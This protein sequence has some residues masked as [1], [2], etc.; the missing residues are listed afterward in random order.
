MKKWK[1][2][3]HFQG[4]GWRRLDNTGKLFAMVAGEDL[5]NVFRVSAVLTEEIDEGRLQEA[6]SQTLPEFQVFQVRLRRDFSG[7][8]LRQIPGN[9]QRSRRRPIHAVL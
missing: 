3:K 2:R 8:I 6:L 5:S 9:R 7:I 1:D 4:A